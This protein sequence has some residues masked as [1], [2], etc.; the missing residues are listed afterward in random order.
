M[1]SDNSK[2]VPESDQIWEEIKDL[3][4]SIY[5]L[6]N[7]K[8]SDHIEKLPVPGNTLYVRLLSSA[9]ISALEPALGNKYEI[10]QA[11][12]YTLIKRATAP[13]IEEE[14]K[15]PKQYLRRH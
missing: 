9:A 4:I 2:K 12:Q 7:Q 14:N 15:G 3:P 10:E 1:S 11:D 5:A 8:V 6:P 13:V